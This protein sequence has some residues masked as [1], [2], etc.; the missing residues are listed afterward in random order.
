[1]DHEPPFIATAS[2]S[3]V[4]RLKLSKVCYRQMNFLAGSVKNKGPSYA[5]AGPVLFLPSRQKGASQT[6]VENL[7][8]IADCISESG[9]LLPGTFQPVC[10]DSH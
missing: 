8:R 10:T 4:L 7:P 5:F 9:V 2:V 1:M 3:E 6:P